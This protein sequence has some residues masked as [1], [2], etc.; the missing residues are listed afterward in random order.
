MRKTFLVTTAVVSCLA[1][2]A[3]FAQ[4][5]PR[6]RFEQGRALGGPVKPKAP[7]TVAFLPD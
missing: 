7:E 6:A 5:D 3:A 4:S 2:A 1:C